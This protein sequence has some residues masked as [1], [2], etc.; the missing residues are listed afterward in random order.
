MVIIK[1]YFPLILLLWVFT[2]FSGLSLGQSL[3]E[4]EEPPENYKFQIF[5]EEEEALAKVFAGC[6]KI[7]SEFLTL[8]REGHEYFKVLMKRPDIETTFQ[9]YIGKKGDVIE[10]YSI[11]L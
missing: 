5:L 2:F 10:R 1:R 11:A 9:V 8:T 7:E 3:L 4:E 6:D